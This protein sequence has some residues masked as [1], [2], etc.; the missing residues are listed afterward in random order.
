MR[1]KAVAASSHTITT[2]FVQQPEVT[3]ARVPA[4]NCIPT[5]MWMKQEF[6]CSTVF[7]KTTSTACT[8]HHSTTW[9]GGLLLSQYQSTLFFQV[10]EEEQAELA[11]N[12][13]CLNPLFSMEL[14]FGKQTCSSL[15]HWQAPSPI[16]VGDTAEEMSNPLPSLAG[17]HTAKYLH[18]DYIAVQWGGGGKG[19]LQ[20][21]SCLKAL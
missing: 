6:L 4:P 13:C 8:M 9:G 5:L 10:G 21:C 3:A 12:E 20:I 15:A 16:R 7:C 11:V 17:E 19:A 14:K 2:M 18:R 1:E